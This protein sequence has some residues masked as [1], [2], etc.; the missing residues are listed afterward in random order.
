MIGLLDL[1]SL[2]SLN[3]ESVIGIECEITIMGTFFTI[4]RY[5]ID[6]PALKYILL[7]KS[8]DVNIKSITLES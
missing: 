1:H 2:S 3:L 6:M 7:R 5:H 4:Y 8:N